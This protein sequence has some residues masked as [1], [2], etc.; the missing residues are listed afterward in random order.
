MFLNVYIKNGGR[1]LKNMTALQLRGGIVSEG[2]QNGV[3]VT[4]T[5]FME[6]LAKNGPKCYVAFRRDEVRFLRCPH[7]FVYVQSKSNIR[8]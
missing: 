8:K 7:Q 2:V 1:A 4:N 6:N 3:W 5:H